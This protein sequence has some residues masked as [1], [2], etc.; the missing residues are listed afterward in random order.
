VCDP[1]CNT[2]CSALQRCDISDVVAQAGSCVG[3]WITNEGDACF[4]GTG[5]DSCAAGLS[6]VDGKCKRLCYANTDCKAPNNCCN[7]R[8]EINGFDTRWLGCAPCSP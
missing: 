6:C 8:I 5:T 7:L 3:I 2:G 4:R 1:V